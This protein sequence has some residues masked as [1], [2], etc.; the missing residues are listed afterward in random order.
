MTKTLFIVLMA[1]LVNAQAEPT[2]IH[3]T[4]KTIS[5]D[6]Y[7][8]PLNM[9]D[10]KPSPMA[11][12]QY[13]DVTTPEMTVGKVRQRQLN[14][15][16]LSSPI[17]LVGTDPVSKKWLANN[18]AALINMVAVGMII[19]TSSEKDTVDILKMTSGLTVSTASASTLARRFKL[20][21]Y[22]VLIS[23]KAI[24]Q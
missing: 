4:G 24:Q 14:L 18:K 12:P 13:K 19:N 2:V 15:P 8:E 17:F 5:I 11:K 7:F 21:H 1:T 23:K 20:R 22:P 3:D 6:R 16:L 9:P 10:E